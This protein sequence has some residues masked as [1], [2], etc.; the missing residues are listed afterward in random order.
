MAQRPR[1]SPA[2]TLARL[3]L[4]R[5]EFY[6]VK[7]Q[8]RAERER[9]EMAACTFQPSL[10]EGTK[11]RAARAA[12]AAAPDAPLLPLPDR[13]QQ[14]QLEAERRRRMRRLEREEA[15]LRDCTFT[16]HISPAAAALVPPEVAARPLHD[17]LGEVQRARRERLAMLKARLEAEAE[18]EGSSSSSSKSRRPTI[19]ALSEQLARAGW[20]V[21]DAAAAGEEEGY[22]MGGADAWGEGGSEDGAAAVVRDLQARLL[23]EARRRE[24]QRMQR[25]WAHEQAQAAAC[26]FAPRLSAGT[27]RLVEEDPR[28]AE[29]G[30][31]ERQA[32][33]D[34]EA[35]RRREEEEARLEA[36]RARWFRPAITARGRQQQQL[37]ED[38]TPEERARRLSVEEA[39]RRAEARARRTEAFYAEMATFQPALNLVSRALGRA[40]SSVDDLVYDWRREQ[41]RCRAA[42]E[43][44][45][46]LQEECTFR[47]TLV[48]AQRPSRGGATTTGMRGGQVIGG[49]GDGDGDRRSRT[50]AGVAAAKSNTRSGRARTRQAQEALERQAWEERARAELEACT[51][52]PDTRASRRS[53]ATAVGGATGMGAGAR[54]VIVRGLGSF[55]ARRQQAE[56]QQWERQRAFGAAV[57]GR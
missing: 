57:G 33:L 18:A 25:L 32:L 3:A 16:P 27:R 56:R 15:E 39:A 48:A 24:Q 23:R 22:G 45:A 35:A 26:P 1:P 28:F 41:A 5:R 46:R 51:F 54:P 42:E 9:E 43:A 20:T 12:A 31:I 19:S 30:F 53:F 2:E 52:Q 13:L 21:D 38:E 4:P 37:Q 6:A 49:D 47:P 50:A 40:A 11:R 10:C 14:R 36:E 17:R 44:E 29:L 8:L 7:E 55:L 34:A